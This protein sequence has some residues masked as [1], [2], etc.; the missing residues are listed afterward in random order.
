MISFAKLKGRT[1][2]PERFHFGIAC[3][4]LGVGL[5]RGAKL[6]GLDQPPQLVDAGQ[7]DTLW[8]ECTLADDS[9]HG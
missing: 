5:D 2:A 6:L 4:Q 9:T 8:S 1:R 7:L 3:E